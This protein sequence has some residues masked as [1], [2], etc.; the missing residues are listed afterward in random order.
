MSKRDFNP[1]ASGTTHRKNENFKLRN[2]QDEPYLAGNSTSEL[3]FRRRDKTKEITKSF[4][5]TTSVP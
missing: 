2:S 5:V 1:V 3:E 4:K